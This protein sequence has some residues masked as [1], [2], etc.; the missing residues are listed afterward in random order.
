MPD[1][2]KKRV[3]IVHGLLGGGNGGSEARAMWAAKGLKRDY[4]VSLV[5]VGLVDRARL[6]S[7][8]GAAI[9]PKEI[10]VRSLPMP[11]ALTHKKAPSALRGAF[12]NRALRRVA[13]EYDLMISTYN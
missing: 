6:N 8:Y 2:V 7:F 3:A 10:G 12:A 9:D 11:K 4:E 5:T 1:S 13:R